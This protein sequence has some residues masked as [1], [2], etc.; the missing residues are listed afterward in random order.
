[1]P[2]APA[3]AGAGLAT[4]LG[5]YGVTLDAGDVILSGS[6]VPLAPAAKGDRFAMTLSDKGMP[7]GTCVANFV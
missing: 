1:M 5:A 2:G 4:T 7:I 3:Q 6:L